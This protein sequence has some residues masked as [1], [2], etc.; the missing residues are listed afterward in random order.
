MSRRGAFFDVDHTLWNETSLLTFYEAFLRQQHGT[1]GSSSWSSFLAR[2]EAQR[3]AGT[4]REDLNAWFYR[5]CFHGVE[6]ERIDQVATAWWQARAPRQSFWVH[7]VLERLARH[8]DAGDDVVLVTGSF[9]ELVAPL[10]RHVGATAMLVAPLEEA[11]GAYTGRLLGPPMIGPGKAAAVAAYM[12]ARRL[13]HADT[14]GY[15]DDATD[16]PFLER[17]AHPVVVAREG[18]PLVEVARARGWSTLRADARA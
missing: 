10:A 13:S 1:D 14:W 17:T 8:R 15:G 16:V 6:V 7:S 3:A 18:S 4:S 12:D 9:R 5:E 2:V 11:A